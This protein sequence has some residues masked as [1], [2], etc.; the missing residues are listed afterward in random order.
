[1]GDSYVN[2]WAKSILGR[3]VI[4]NGEKMFNIFKE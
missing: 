1:M 2:I 3:K 4:K